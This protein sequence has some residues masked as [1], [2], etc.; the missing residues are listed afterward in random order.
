MFAPDFGRVPLPTPAMYRNVLPEG[1]LDPG[2]SL[3]GWLYFK[4]VTVQKG[5]VTFDANVKA[6]DGTSLGELSIPY[7]FVKGTA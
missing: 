6:A 5:A 3:E 4:H 2:G 7:T 1:V